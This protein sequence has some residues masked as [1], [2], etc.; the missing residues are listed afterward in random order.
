VSGPKDRAR[1]N[2]G[3]IGQR[4]LALC[5]FAMFGVLVWLAYS[6]R[7]DATINRMAAWLRHGVDAIVHHLP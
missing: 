7:H 5:V 6:G 1:R 4:L 3:G 2:G